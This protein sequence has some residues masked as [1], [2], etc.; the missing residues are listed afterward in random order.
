MGLRALQVHTDE[1]D[2]GKIEEKGSNPLWRSVDIFIQKEDGMKR[3]AFLLA[4]MC[5]LALFASVGAASPHFVVGPTFTDL[6]SSFNASGKIAGLGNDDVTVTLT[7]VGVADTQC[8]N[9]GGN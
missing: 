2:L 4:S 6:G 3:L 8:R 9:K 5:S 1:R 7:A